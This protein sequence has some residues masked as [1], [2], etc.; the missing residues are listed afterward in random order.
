VIQDLDSKIPPGYAGRVW[1]L[2]TTRP[3]HWSYTGLDEGDLWR[4]HLWER[5]CPPGPYLRF[6][7]LALSPMNCH[8]LMSEGAAETP[9]LYSEQVR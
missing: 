4:K 8:T 3:T 2:Y 5:G 6:A 7:N 1:L 9:T